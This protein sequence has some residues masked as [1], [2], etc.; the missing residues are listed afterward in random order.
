M[1]THF[2][3]LHYRLVLGW[4]RMVGRDGRSRSWFGMVPARRAG[5]PPDSRRDGGATMPGKRAVLR[6]QATIG[7]LED[8]PDE[9]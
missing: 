6:S 4:S 2:R 1:Q 7:G 5:R 9:R 8:S 3:F